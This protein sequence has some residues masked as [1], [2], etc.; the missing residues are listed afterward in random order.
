MQSAAG[1]NSNKK[2]KYVERNQAMWGT[3]DFEKLLPSDHPVRT[4]WELTGQFD[5]SRFGTQ[6]RTF[7]GQAGS[8]AWPPRLLLAVWLY[9]YQSGIS[10]ANRLSERMS[11]EP[12]LMWLCGLQT[13]NVHTLCDFRTEHGD[14]L[15]ELMKNVIAALIAEKLIDTTTVVHDGTKM[16]ARAGNGS[17]HRHASVQAKLQQAHAYMEQVDRSSQEV[18]AQQKSARERAARER[19][20]RLTE[21]C[22]QIE[23][24]TDKGKLR[25]VSISE[26]EARRMRHGQQGGFAYSYNVQLSTEPSNNFIVGVSVTPEQNDLQQL[27]PAL[28]TVQQFTGGKPERIIADSGYVTRQNIKAMAEAGVELIAP[29]LATSQRQAGNRKKLGIAPDFDVSRFVQEGGGWR[30]PANQL[31]V[32]ISQKKKHGEVTQTFQAAAGIC[33]AC[34]YKP[35]CCPAMPERR[36]HHIVEQA[37]I[38]QHLERMQTERAKKLYAMRCKVAEFPHMRIKGNWGLRRFSVRGLAKAA[39]EALWMVLAYNFSQWMW[40]QRAQATAAA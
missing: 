9:G 26:P 31:L 3:I 2:Y 34:V 22:Q 27:E 11:W 25:R 30:C 13:I 32:Q 15:Q 36:I 6:V 37:V 23:A 4:V 10:S 12:A 16:Q 17:G 18:S 21:A 5:L 14:A 28:N 7:E 33:S 8:P 24:S 38:V 1:G 39:T 19:V 29:V 35:Q 20:Q 40:T